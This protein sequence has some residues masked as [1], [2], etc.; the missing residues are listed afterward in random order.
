MVLAARHYP[1]GY[2]WPYTVISALASQKH[3]P[4]GSIW[5]AGA[6]SMSMVLLWPYVSIITQALRRALP[7]ATMYTIGSLRVGIIFAAVVG[8]ERLL[9]RDIS[10]WLYKSHELLALVAIFAL[11]FGILGLL[12]QVM[13]RRKIYL[14]PAIFVATPLLAIFIT[15][16]WLYAQQSDL[17]WTGTGWREKGIPLWLSFAFWQ[18]LEIA[19]LWLG[20]GLLFFRVLVNES[21]RQRD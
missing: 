20:L 21:R 4:A 17:G 10:S 9:F 16:I 14:L 18:W 6:L 5:F 1:G 8:V 12:I 13:H 3:N 7:S 11:Y 2:D 19:F 15:Q